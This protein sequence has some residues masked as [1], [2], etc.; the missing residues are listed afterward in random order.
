ARVGAA[1][2]AAVAAGATANG[3][4]E[5]LS[6]GVSPGGAP[7]LEASRRALLVAAARLALGAIALA[8][9]VS[10]DVSFGTGL[11]EAGIGAGLI[12]FALVSPGGRRR[13]RRLQASKARSEAQ[14]WWR[15]SLTAPPLFWHT[16]VPGLSPCPTPGFVA[17]S[18]TAPA[19]P[20]GPWRRLLSWRDPRRHRHAG[21]ARHRRPSCRRSAA[22]R[23][24]ARPRR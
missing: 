6:R 20:R 8:A 13:P 10:G 1:T 21:R 12:L 23:R 7:R 16:R 11:T 4:S 9:A 5:F 17:G 22:D 14:P 19:R 3:V 15:G 2:A 18:D 24:A